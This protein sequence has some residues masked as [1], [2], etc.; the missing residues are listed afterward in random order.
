[1]NLGNYI[2]E[3]TTA[4]NCDNYDCQNNGNCFIKNNEAYC[5]CTENYYGL[6]CEL[7]LENAINITNDLIDDFLTL[8]LLLKMKR[9]IKVMKIKVVIFIIY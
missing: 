7:G 5:N 9:N 2:F 8:N 3:D 4:S 1:M 6:K